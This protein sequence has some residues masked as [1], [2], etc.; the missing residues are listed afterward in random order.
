M[1]TSDLTNKLRK[2]LNLV[3]DALN[4]QNI[5]SSG[6]AASKKQNKQGFDILKDKRLE[7]SQH[8]KMLSSNGQ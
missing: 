8:T 7:G 6:D 3:T 5:I 2:Q 4:A 1:K